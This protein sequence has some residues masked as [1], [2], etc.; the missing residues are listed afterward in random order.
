MAR[1]VVVLSAITQA[2]LKIKKPYMITQKGSSD[3]YYVNAKAIQPY[4]ALSLIA[5]F[6][7]LY[8]MLF[9]HKGNV[10]GYLL[11]TLEETLLMLVVAATPLFTAMR[12]SKATLLAKQKAAISVVGIPFILFAFC[13]YLAT[14][15]ISTAYLPH[16]VQR[17]T[18][19]PKTSHTK[20][21]EG[22]KITTHIV[23]PG[24]SLWGIAKTYYGNGLCWQQIENPRSG[25]L[26]IHGDALTIVDKND[27]CHIRS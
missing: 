10:Q 6:T 23:K 5:L 22:N 21:Q 2:V 26:I 7:S 16:E 20:I 14:P 1:W 4:V 15:F 13:T 3:T 8:Y 12:I 9:A 18:I 25:K 27:D 24:D 17:V 11:Y 19:T